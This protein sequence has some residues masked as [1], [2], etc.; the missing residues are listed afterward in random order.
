MVLVDTIKESIQKHLLFVF[1][2]GPLFPDS[3]IPDKIPH[4]VGRQGECAA[5]FKHLTK[6]DTRLVDVWGPP[7]FGKTSVAINVSHHLKEMEIPVYFTSLRGMKSKDEL[8]SKLLSIFADAKQAFYVSSSDW[9]IQCLQ[10][11]KNPF[12]LVLDNADDLLESGD[13]NLKENVLGFTEEILAQC[14]QIKL[15]LTTR[16][17]VDYLSHKLPIHQERV[18]VLDKVSSISLVKSLLLPD[19]SDDD[20][21]CIVKECG[22]VPLAMRLMCS[23]IK[24]EN[25][26][27]AELLEER[28]VSPLVE[29]LD[30]ESFSDDTRLKTIINSSFE[31]LAEHER[32]ALVSL[33]VFPSGFGVNEARAVLDLKTVRL[34]KKVIGSLKRKSLIDCSDDIESFTIHS[35]LR[36]FIDER[37]IANQDIQAMFHAAQLRFYD[38]HITNFG[39]ANE[40]FLTGHSNEAFQVF[41]GQRENILLSLVNGAKECTLYHKA[42]E[43]LSKA[44]LFFYAV[45]PNEEV[46]F[47]RLYS[48]AVEEAQKRQRRDDE[49]NLLAAKSF[50]SLGGFY[51]NRQSWD[52]SLQAGIHDT[53]T[54]PA[55]RLCY[56]G[57]HQLL[58]GHIDDGISSLRTSVDRLNSNC[59]ENVLKVLAYHVLAVCYRKKGDKKN[60]S[61]SETLCSNEC[62]STSFSPAV[63]DVFLRGSSS[64]GKL[65][66]LAS[67]VEQDVFF[68]V[69]IA[70]LL[71]VLYRELEFGKQAETE[72]SLMT[73]HLVGLHKVL[74]PLFHKGMLRVRILE[75]CCNALY[76]LSCFKEAVEGFQMITDKLEKT[77]GNEHKRTAQ[78]YLFRGLALKGL[79][80]PDA[81]FCCLKKALDIRR[82]LL[83]K[84]LD[85]RHGNN[86]VKETIDS[87]EHCLKMQE[88]VDGTT[89]GQTNDFKVICEEIK[90]ALK[91]LGKING[92]DLAEI[93]TN[94]NQLGY[95]YWLM[96]DTNGALELFQQ[97][98][99]IREEHVVDSVD[100]ET[101]LRNIANAYF[102]MNRNTEAGKANQSALNLRKSLGIEDHAETAFI[103]HGLGMNHLKLGEL[104][105]A[106][107]AHHQG[108][109][110]RKKHLGDHTLTVHS[111]NLT[112]YAYFEMGDYEAAIEY[113]RNAAELAKTLLGD[114]EETASHFL[115]VTKVYLQI[116]NYREALDACQE[117]K[118]IRLKLLGDHVDTATAFHC[119]GRICFKMSDFKGA[120]RSFRRASAL[121]SNLLGDHLDTALSCHCLG[122]A[123]V[124][125]NDFSGALESLHTALSIRKEE[126]GFHSDTA[127]TLELLGRAY[128]GLGQRDLASEQFKSALEMREYLQDDHV[129]TALSDPSNPFLSCYS[130]EEYLSMIYPKQRRV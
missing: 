81:A 53:N 61:Q 90:S 76:S 6:G 118:T 114:H 10:Q 24:E 89:F 54:C 122:E 93:A 127:A 95:C 26:S 80:K 108:L 94:Y 45:L 84:N 123:Q 97:A 129:K 13:A 69:V 52:Q 41:L 43:V 2:K 30:N 38:Y 74:I 78:N 35:L 65:T 14:S 120:V 3:C 55:K 9:L 83:Q 91:S 28:K 17:S 109:K 92:E 4:F 44:E 112:G 29:V 86:M 25:V 12:V 51:V 115:N 88:N 99:K 33:A 20:C 8:V 101:C 126:T 106:L 49:C 72:L 125:M 22:Q 85:A 21:S 40:Q 15:L 42:V 59:D 1:I 96:D 18:G 70:E 62:K 103:Y 111:F 104:S 37:R 128:E 121:R 36:S 124:T 64:A 60:A 67:I 113:F 79:Q 102:K 11:L 66:D 71:P 63:R 39:V 130:E 50:G 73:H 32:N 46:L 56:L 58:C 27:L 82:K 19:V 119:F 116:G 23:I 98:L 31:R 7:G 100:K 47:D 87:L 48:T 75:A 77:L 117:S 16:E 107:N 105:E 57:V 68:F 110:L 34:T 5:V